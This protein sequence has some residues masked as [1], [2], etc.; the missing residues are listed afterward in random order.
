M[1]DPR[2]VHLRL[3]SEYSVTDGIVRIDAAVARA[4]AC[5]MP[6][7]GLTDLANVFGLVKFYLAARGKGIKPVIGCDIHLANETDADRPYRMLLLCASRH[8][9]AKLCE[10]L[11]QAHLRPRVRGRAEI[12]RAMLA[13][14]GVDGLIAL[15]GAAQ[16]DVGEALSQ[17]HAAQAKER[18]AYWAGLFPQGFY[19]EVQRA[20]PRGHAQQEALVAASAQ[21]A[22]EMGLPLVATH[23]IQFLE[24]GD[25]LAHE[26]RVCIAEGYMLADNRRPRPYTEEQYFKSAEEMAELF[27]DLPDAL[28]NSVEIARRCNLEIDLYKN[29]L[30]DFPTPDG[31]SLDE[32]LTAQA[33]QGLEKR[34]LQ[35]Y[36]V[37]ADREKQRP[38][39]E[40]R[41]KVETRIIIQMGFSGYFLIVADFINWAKKNDVPV[42][43]G[44]GSG[45]GSLVAY[46]L[47]ITN[48]DPLKYAL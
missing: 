19:L 43:P 2:F 37:D 35:L 34:L 6:A 1:P 38:I 23:P 18:A 17:G 41:L 9:Y 44:R 26:A 24:R 22:S 4:T 15:S 21:L 7:L 29:C 33:E 10:L 27:S 30:P 47:G 14:I 32:F 46:S 3:H 8:G 20:H 48:L 40:D 12:T 5:G 25:F 31:A 28:E 45:A 42:G 39:Y 36:P 16:G 11:T 13:E